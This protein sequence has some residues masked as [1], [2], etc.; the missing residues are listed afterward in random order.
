[1]NN[2]GVG[3]TVDRALDS[4]SDPA[5]FK[6]CTK[7]PYF[8]QSKAFLMSNRVW[9]TAHIKIP[10]LRSYSEKNGKEKEGMGRVEGRKMKEGREGRK[11]KGGKEEKEARQTDQKVSSHSS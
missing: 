6:S 10:S 8:H 11:G 5:R 1:M 3:D 4:G 9:G 7:L 2:G